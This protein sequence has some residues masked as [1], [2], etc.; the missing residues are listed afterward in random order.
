[1]QL[2]AKDL[3]VAQRLLAGANTRTEQHQALHRLAGILAAAAAV[4]E[5]QQLREIVDRLRGGIALEDDIRRQIAR[6]MRE[7]SARVQLL[8]ARFS[9]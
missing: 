9:D 8:A 5:E 6:L 7:V 3:L 4:D 1:V 2:I